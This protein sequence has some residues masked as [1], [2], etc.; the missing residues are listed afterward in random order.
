MIVKINKLK[1]FGIY[2]NF[3]WHPSIPPF[4]HFNLI[5]GWNYSGKTTLSR[6]FR[7]LELGYIHNVG[8]EE[9]VEF[10]FESIDGSKHSHDFTTRNLVRV[11]NQDFIKENLKWDIQDDIH[12]IVILGEENI[13]LQNQLAAERINLSSLE[14]LLPNAIAKRAAEQD[15]INNS[16]TN[17]ARDI[18]HTLRLTPFNRTHLINVIGSVIFDHRSFLLDVSEWQ[19]QHTKATSTEQKPLINFKHAHVLNLA[20]LKDEVENILRRQCLSGA[21]ID[22][23]LEDV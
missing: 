2:K 18:A 12:P 22:K 10:E 20:N 16:L 19:T 17:K 14:A 15:S 3:T 11:F 21:K 23:L 5:Y 4:T 7:C 9:D 8:P 1:N 6:A 13:E